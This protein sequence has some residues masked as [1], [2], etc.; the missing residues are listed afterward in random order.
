M[1]RWGSS[2]RHPRSPYA[3]SQASPRCTAPGGAG[4]AQIK[5]T[6]RKA[7]RG[8]RI[9]T[10]SAPPVRVSRTSTSFP[11]QDSRFRVSRVKSP[12]SV[13]A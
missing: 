9:A 11:A 8:P 6:D 5:V 13:A 12:L 1:H 3:R 7:E 10:W 2:G 4:R